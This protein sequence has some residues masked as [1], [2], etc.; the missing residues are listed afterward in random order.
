MDSLSAEKLD[1][2]SFVPLYYQLQ[3]VLKEHIESGSWQP[4]EALP[5]EPELARRFGI[6]RVV[7]RQALAILEDDRQIYRVRGRG[8]FVARPKLDS[9]AGGLSRMLATPRGSDVALVV[10]EKRTVVPE[11][12]IRRRLQ[13][14]GTEAILRVT[15]QLSL[16]EVPLAISYSFFRR[17]E[18]GWLDDA[19]RTG[20]SVP[21]DLTLPSDL[22]LA[23]SQASIET[24][25]CGQFEADRFGVPY[26]TSV[27]LALCTEY[28]KAPEG[29]SAFEVA[30]V[31][32][33][34]DLVQLRLNIIGD[35]PGEL[36]AHLSLNDNF[37]D[38]QPRP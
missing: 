25:Q 38:H 20:W 8:T 5:S 24:S 32:Y 11:V 16:R 36:E 28:R 30:R 14:S 35:Q 12:S 22:V 27:F 6:S 26:R 34:G 23:H 29:T 37:S 3:E 2:H 9:R 13:A 4:G 7:V 17:A 33:R 31:E 1:R 19:L 18:V 15:T 10:L 21:P